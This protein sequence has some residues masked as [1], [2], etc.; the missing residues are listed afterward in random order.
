MYL[1]CYGWLEGFLH[2]DSFSCTSKKTNKN[3]DR[4]RN[5]GCLIDLLKVR[6]CGSQNMLHLH[7]WNGGPKINPVKLTHQIVGF[8]GTNAETPSLG[9]CI[10]FNH[11]MYL[12]KSLFFFATWIKGKRRW[13][14]IVTPLRDT[15]C[16]RVM[17]DSNSHQNLRMKVCLLLHWYWVEKNTPLTKDASCYTITVHLW[18]EFIQNGHHP[19]PF[20]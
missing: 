9:L 20:M 19:K 11:L 8:K 14:W 13:S 15:K 4:Q 3:L 1:Y 6:Y 10:S 7:K 18:I 12:W 2:P 17:H 5:I 16:G